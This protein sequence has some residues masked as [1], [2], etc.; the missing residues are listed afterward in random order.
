MRELTKPF[1]FGLFLTLVVFPPLRAQTAG[2]GS[3]DSNETPAN[4]GSANKTPAGQAPDEVM[5][6]LSDLVH[7]GR[8]AEAQQLTAGLLLA[9]PDDQRL[10]KAK[11]LL[12]KSLATAS[13]KAIPNADPSA[14]DSVPTPATG[15]AATQ[16]TGMDKV[17]YNALIE[18]ARQAQQNTDL[19]QQKASLK[20]FMDQSSEFLQKHPTEMLLW[21]LRAASALSL[22]DPMAGYEAGQKLLAAGVME[23]NDPN[24]QRL[25]VQLKNK[26]WLDREEATKQGEYGWIV[27]TWSVT[28][29]Y[30]WKFPLGGHLGGQGQGANEVF[31]ISGAGIDGYRVNDGVRDNGPD[32]RGTL[33]DSGDIRWERYFSPE[34]GGSYVFSPY[35]TKPKTK[36]YPFGWQRVISSEIVGDKKTMTMVI[37]SQCS[38]ATNDEPIKRTVNLS[39]KKTASAQ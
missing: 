18:L 35:N 30:S 34:G 12:D 29:S 37:P 11:A 21:Q 26:G 4:K 23:S 36:A 24:S 25:L 38:S 7:A 15:T 17:D 2:T 10:I 6:K 19:E 39:F 27:G 8:H 31:V 20:Q 13:A 32:M 5:K 3:A 22:N 16:L 33:L 9:Y 14:S 28:W 1:I